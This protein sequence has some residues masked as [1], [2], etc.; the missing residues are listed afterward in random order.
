MET[1]AHFFLNERQTGTAKDGVGCWCGRLQS[2]NRRNS[3]TSYTTDVEGVSPRPEK[4]GATAAVDTPK[5]FLKTLDSE[6][7]G[8]RCGGFRHVG[9][10]A[11]GLVG[12]LSALTPDERSRM[13][14]DLSSTKGIG[15]GEPETAPEAGRLGDGDGAVIREAEHR[16]VPSKFARLVHA[17]FFGR[18]VG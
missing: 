10:I 13:L 4:N 16:Q 9:E 11:N 3:E 12:Q 2:P 15:Q 8:E 17:A 6:L 18:L 1:A 14:I 7:I 5:P